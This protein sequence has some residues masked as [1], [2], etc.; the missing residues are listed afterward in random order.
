[1]AKGTDVSDLF[2]RA[3]QKFDSNPNLVQQA[4]ANG[5]MK[6][7]PIPTDVSTSIPIGTNRNNT[8]EPV[9]YEMRPEKLAFEKAQKEKAEKREFVKF[10]EELNEDEIENLLYLAKDRVIVQKSTLEEIGRRG[11]DLGL[12]KLE[13]AGCLKRSFIPGENI[14]EFTI[15]ALGRRVLNMVRGN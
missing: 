6:S 5:Y 3:F 15:T 12:E 1:M 11:E 10:L 13:D 9:K 2:S 8:I 7:Q 14:Y 4:V